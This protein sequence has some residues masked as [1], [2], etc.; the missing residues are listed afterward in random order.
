[1]G[2]MIRCLKSEY[3]LDQIENEINRTDSIVDIDQMYDEI[4]RKNNVYIDDDKNTD[5]NENEHYLNNSLNEIKDRKKTYSM[6]VPS[7]S[8]KYKI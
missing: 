5:E 1:M 2:G 8:S 7:T 3:N 6:Y 4:K